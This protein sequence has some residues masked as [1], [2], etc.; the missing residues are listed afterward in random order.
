MV[1][2]REDE[3]LARAA[4]EGLLAGVELTPKPG[5]PDAREADLPGLR[6]S[7]RAL[8]PGLAAMA[9]AARRTGEPSRELR[10]ELGAIGRAT[11]RDMA[12]AD[13]GATLHHGAVWPL[14][15]LVAGAALAPGGTVEDITGLAGRIA[16]HPDA[17]APRRPSPGSAVSV[18]YGAAGA[19]GEA[20]AGFPHVRRASAALRAARDGGAPEPEARLN[21]LL[22]VM[23][24]LQDTGPLHAAGPHALREV[25]DGA[26]E[27]LAGRVPLDAF[28]RRLRERGLHPRGS[29]HLLAAAL[30]LDGLR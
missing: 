25:Q 12:R 5:L 11:E 9:G 10:V 18:R 3:V 28:D 23:T 24:T 8:E 14:G 30:F 4:V 26:R 20:R 7:A 2:T 19:K 21:A 27:V 22:T 1:V 29:G 17:R 6:W 16:A 13:G 15:L